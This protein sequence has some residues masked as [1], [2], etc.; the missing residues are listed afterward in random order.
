M[1]Y[2]ITDINIDK[3]K[4][5]RTWEVADLIKAVDI[6]SNLEHKAELDEHCHRIVLT[7]VDFMGKT[8]LYEVYI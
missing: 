5:L 6:L 7:Q 8:E 3:N 2:L 1:S 4:T